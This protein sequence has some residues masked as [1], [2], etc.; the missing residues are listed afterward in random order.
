[1]AGLETSKNVVF[2]LGKTWV[3]GWGSDRLSPAIVRAPRAGSAAAL[4]DQVGAVWA[5]SQIIR[6]M[7]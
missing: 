1:M 3:F 2:L 5:L 4:L 6:C 7:L